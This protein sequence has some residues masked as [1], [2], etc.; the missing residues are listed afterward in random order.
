MRRK[1]EMRMNTYQL[2]APDGFQENVQM[3][4]ATS[5][6]RDGKARLLVV[7]DEKN[8]L[9][10]LTR[11]LSSF[12]YEVEGAGGGRHGLELFTEGDFDLVITDLNMPDMDGGRLARLIK[13]VSS[14]T[15]VILITGDPDASDQLQANGGAVD[16]LMYKPFSLP[17]V[18]STIDRFL[19]ES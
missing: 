9:E 18:L 3:R 2:R 12:G 16:A 15:P 4:G 8:I 1:G 10:I 13:D 6:R 14:E 7:D 17:H 19:S 11:L 5:F